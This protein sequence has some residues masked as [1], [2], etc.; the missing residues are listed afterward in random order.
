MDKQENRLESIKD[1]KK[2]MNT[3]D[4]VLGALIGGVVG[5]AC[6]LY[7]APKSEKDIRSTLNGQAALLKQK[8]EELRHVA[9]SKGSDLVAIA[10][11]KTTNL[12]KNIYKET[13]NK[14]D[15]FRA[16]EVQN[17]RTEYVSIKPFQS[18]HEDIQKKL[19][20]AQ[21]A[22]DEQEKKIKA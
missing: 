19:E 15:E 12:S 1:E 2:G 4:F 22:L 16:K 21:K 6:A 3:M 7:L 20:E 17:N 10:K 11:D 5:A 13:M 9:F 18:S 8:G 14:E